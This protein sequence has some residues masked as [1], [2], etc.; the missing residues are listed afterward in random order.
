MGCTLRDEHVLRVLRRESHDSK[1]Q[2]AG[3]SVAGRGAK[4]WQSTRSLRR[5]HSVRTAMK[6]GSAHLVAL[7]EF[8]DDIRVKPATTTSNE[9]PAVVVDGRDGAWSQQNGLLCEAGVAVPDKSITR[10]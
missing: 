8:N 7:Q 10:R 9:R 2:H 1:Q 3:E 4:A 6:E 5:V